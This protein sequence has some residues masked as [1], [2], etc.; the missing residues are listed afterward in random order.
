MTPTFAHQSPLDVSSPFP[1][2]FTNSS[3]QTILVPKSDPVSPPPVAAQ[4]WRGRKNE[5]E[6]GG[7]ERKCECVSIRVGKVHLAHKLA[8]V[9]GVVLEAA[10]LMVYWVHCCFLTTK[11]KLSVCDRDGLVYKTKISASW[12][13][14]DSAAY[15]WFILTY[16]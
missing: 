8:F 13:F 4:A 7:R 16:S 12:L 2:P 11:A 1:P 6:W 9:K 15:H 10:T 5:E 3:L 14:T